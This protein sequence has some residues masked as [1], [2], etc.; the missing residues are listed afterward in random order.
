V[1]IQLVQSLL[2]AGLFYSD[3]RA[4]KAAEVLGLEPGCDMLMSGRRE[5][6][7][8]DFGMHVYYA[9]TCV[10]ADKEIA[11]MKQVEAWLGDDRA[12]T[13]EF[14]ISSRNTFA[15]FR[16]QSISPTA[17]ATIG[18]VKGGRKNYGWN[19]SP[20]RFLEIMAAATIKSRGV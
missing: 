8:G 5:V 1:L 12:F 9:R 7:N 13:G 6:T 11:D 19:P 16:I 15:T 3:E 20:A 14:K 17:V 4:A 18:R 10:T 2:D